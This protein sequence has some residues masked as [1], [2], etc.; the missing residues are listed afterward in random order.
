MQELNLVERHPD[1]RNPY[2]KVDPKDSQLE[3]ATV[4]KKT[5]KKKERQRGPRLTEL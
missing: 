3:E 5:K 1:Y 4:K 2:R